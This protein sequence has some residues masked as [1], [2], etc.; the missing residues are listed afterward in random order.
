[1]PVTLWTRSWIA[2]PRS[3]ERSKERPSNDG[4]GARLV[5]QFAL[6]L[7]LELLDLLVL[8]HRR[9][10]PFLH[11]R[12]VPDA[13]GVALQFPIELDPIG[14]KPAHHRRVHRVG[15][16]DLAEQ[17]RAAI[18]LETFAPDDNDAVDVGARLRPDLETGKL[19]LDVHRQ[20]LSERDEAGMHLA[21]NRA[22]M[23]TNCLILRQKFGLWRDFVQEFPDRQSIPDPNPFVSK[24]RNED[25]RRQQQYLG[26]RVGVTG[27]DDDLL[28]IDPGELGHQ[29]AS[30]RPGR[31]VPAADGQGCLRH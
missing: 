21:A 5:T 26:A 10:T 18:G 29:P 4:Y 7:G 8:G 20:R 9:L 1:M 14:A 6:K 30:E 13:L 3:K 12:Q 28:E 22:A 11:R 23:G 25:S 17:E 16:A 19:S 31:I 27:S 24:A 15:H 2:P